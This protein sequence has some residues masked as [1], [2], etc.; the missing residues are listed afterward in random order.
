MPITSALARKP[1]MQRRKSI[2]RNEWLLGDVLIGLFIAARENAAARA[3]RARGIRRRR[4]RAARERN[5][6]SSRMVGK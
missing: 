2:Q 4:R 3:A 1:L 6:S 5:S